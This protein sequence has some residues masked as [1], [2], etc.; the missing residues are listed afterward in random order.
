MQ[1][2]N[3]KKVAIVTGASSGIGKA[4]AVKF[5]QMGYTVHAAARRLYAMKDLEAQGAMVHQVDLR[6]VAEIASFANA[7]IA[8]SGRIDV[9]VNSAGY[10]FYGAVE[11]APMA[12]AKEQLARQGVSK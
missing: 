1:M 2:N 5:L 6:N 8:A 3:K 10:G 12:A 11:E 7:V 4:A 9:L